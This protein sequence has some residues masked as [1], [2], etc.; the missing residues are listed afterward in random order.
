MEW[1]VGATLF[2]AFVWLG[3]P[4]KMENMDIAPRGGRG[5]AEDDGQRRCARA[6]LAGGPLVSPLN[7]RRLFYKWFLICPPD[8]PPHTIKPAVREDR[9]LLRLTY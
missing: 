2:C 5:A 4:E 7:A 3:W 1:L 9:W 8:S 6:G